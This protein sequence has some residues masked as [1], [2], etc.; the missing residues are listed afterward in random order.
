MADV[1]TFL[2]YLVKRLTDLE[3]ASLAQDPTAS[4]KEGRV[5]PV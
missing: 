3:L 2:G 5:L 1:K 4:S